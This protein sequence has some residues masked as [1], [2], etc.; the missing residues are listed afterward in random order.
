MKIW[1]FLAITG[2]SVGG[3][4]NVSQITLSDKGSSDISH[5][6]FETQTE[7]EET[8]KIWDPIIEA[9]EAETGEQLFIRTACVEFDI[10]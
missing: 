5:L 7:C 9:R 3:E 4:T 1:V 2:L 8:R 10:P 6:V